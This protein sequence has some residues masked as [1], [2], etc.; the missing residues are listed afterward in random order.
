MDK[1]KKNIDF[2]DS[3]ELEQL[4]KTEY[5]LRKIRKEQMN[6]QKNVNDFKY[7]TLKS[8]LG[9]SIDIPIHFETIDTINDKCFGTITIEKEEDFEL[10]NIKT[11]GFLIEIPNGCI[12]LISIDSILKQLL[13]IESISEYKSENTEG[14]I[15]KT[16]AVEGVINYILLT[17]GKRGIYQLKLSVD[18]FLE[19]NY[20]DVINNIFSSFCITDL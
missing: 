14:K 8:N 17:T 6:F 19:N 12:E 16:R 3:T 20:K 9:Y 2:L 18:E 5:Y 1:Y 4:K 15:V 11:Q 7:K 10:Y 13:N